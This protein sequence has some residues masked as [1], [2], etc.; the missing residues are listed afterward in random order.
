M[1]II[2]FKTRLC[3]QLC[4]KRDYDYSCVQNETMSIVV[5][6]TRLC[7]QLCSKRDSVYSCVQNE[8]MSIVVFKT[9][10]S[11]QFCSNRDSV[12]SCVQNE[13]LSIVVFK[14]R[15][16]LLL[17]SKRDVVQWCVQN[18][19]LS[20]V[21]FKI[22]HPSIKLTKLFAFYYYL[23]RHV[24]YLHMIICLYLFICITCHVDSVYLSKHS[25]TI[26]DTVFNLQFIHL[27]LY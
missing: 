2:V 4:S 10:L 5:L 13:T 26:F 27:I 8:T 19:T 20:S 22:Y 6:K 14:S 9:R 18:E 12:Y 23:Y 7:L 15:L 21:V 17:C 1:P 16:S 3:L 11:L 24:Q 25:N